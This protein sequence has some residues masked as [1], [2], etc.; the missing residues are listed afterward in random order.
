MGGL[1]ATMSAGSAANPACKGKMDIQS[2]TNRPRRFMGPIVATLAAV[3]DRLVRSVGLD[4][5]DGPSSQK[6]TPR[7]TMVSR[8][9]ISTKGGG[10]NN[11][12]I[13]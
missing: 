4:R 1:G 13:D 5:S 6:K 7:E 3:V 10:I 2:K 12:S 8:E 9:A 11:T